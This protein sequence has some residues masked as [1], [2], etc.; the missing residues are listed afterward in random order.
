MSRMHGKARLSLI[1]ALGVLLAGGGTAGVLAAQSRQP[2]AQQSQRERSREE[3]RVP[4]RSSIQVP[5]DEADE[6]RKNDDADS[7]AKGSGRA[8]G[9]E[10]PEMEEQDVVT[11]QSLARISVEQAKTA[12]LTAVPGTVT[13][14]GI[15]NED[16][17][18]VYGV[19]VRTAAGVQDVKVDAGNGKILHVEKDGGSN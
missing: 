6:Q 3:D 1:V 4:Y 19:R 8:K 15:E 17:N 2:G 10:G 14:A 11:L 12:A 7:E 18:L 13:G 9:R 5:D 16:G